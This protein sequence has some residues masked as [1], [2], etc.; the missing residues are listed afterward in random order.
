MSGVGE[1]D[2]FPVLSYILYTCYIVCQKSQVWLTSVGMVAVETQS[3][4]VEE[5]SSSAV[6]SALPEQRGPVQWDYFLKI[7]KVFTVP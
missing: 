2:M 3:L 7:G 1:H 6:C 5:C 4:P